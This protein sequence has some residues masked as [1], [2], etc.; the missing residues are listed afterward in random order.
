MNEQGVYYDGFSEPVDCNLNL[1]NDKLY[2]YK[3]DRANS[4]IIW[5][6][7]KFNS[8][9]PNGELLEITYGSGPKQLLVCKG[10][11]ALRLYDFYIG[12]VQSGNS[13]PVAKR[14]R[15][16][17]LIGLF[18][19]TIFLV[20]WFWFI[21]WLGEKCV[22]LVSKEYEIEMGKGLSAGFANQN[23]MNDSAAYFVNKFV[24]HLKID[25]TYPLEVSVVR[26][27]EVN[28]FAFPGGRIFIYTGILEKMN[29][30]EELVALLGHEVSHVTNQHSLKSIFRSAATSLIFSAFL[31]DVSGLSSA[32]F[33]QVNQLKQLHYSRELEAEADNTG[34]QLM[35]DNKVDPKGM[36]RLLTILK[37]VSVDEPGIMKYLSTHPDTESRIESVVSNPLTKNSYSGN[38]ALESIFNNIKRSLKEN[39]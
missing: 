20:S 13:K 11:I 25:D 9:L 22:G 3:K 36:L 24:K 2:I 10:D 21:P 37:D 15:T 14:R 5:D 28:A 27:E 34:L 31:G 39:K 7:K 29:S 19:I 35:V 38:L 16:L 23:D 30:Y 33:S 18:C 6:V 4:L 12:A 26:S 32:V 1:L 17:I 8:C